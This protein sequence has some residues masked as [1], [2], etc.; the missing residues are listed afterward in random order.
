M[1]EAE[2]PGT[3]GRSVSRPRVSRGAPRAP[4]IFTGRCHPRPGGESHSSPLCLRSGGR[5]SGG[6]GPQGWSFW[7]PWGWGPCPRPLSASGCWFLMVCGVLTRR[8]LVCTSPASVFPPRS[9]SV[10]TSETP[11]PCGDTVAGSRARLNLTTR[12]KTLFPD[13]VTCTGPRPPGSRATITQRRCYLLSRG[14]D[15]RTDREVPVPRRDAPGGRRLCGRAG[16]LGRQR[17]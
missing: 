1:W 11:S 3:G 12:A 14:V 6:R 17:P 7:S 15:V 10:C 13:Q 8:H 9:R 16:A 5:G 4:S 2:S